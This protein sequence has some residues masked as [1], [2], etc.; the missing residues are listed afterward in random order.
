VTTI[1]RAGHD[2]FLARLW[3]ACP[4]TASCAGRSSGL[5]FQPLA[6]DDVG[7]IEAMDPPTGAPGE[8]TP[9]PPTD[10]TLLFDTNVLRDLQRGRID[11]RLARRAAERLAA[12]P[13]RGCFSPLTLLELGSHFTDD[14]RRHFPRYQ[15]ALRAALTL[16]LHALPEPATFLRATLTATEGSLAHAQLAGTAE[17]RETWRLTQLLARARSYEELVYGQRVGWDG[18]RRRVAFLPGSWRARRDEGERTFVKSL[19]EMRHLLAS[20]DRTSLAPEL[21]AEPSRTAFERVQRARLGLPA[22]APDAA[23]SPGFA[24]LFRGWVAIVERLLEGTYDPSSDRNDHHDLGLV[25]Y[26]A[27][28]S[29]TLVTN[30]RGFADKLGENARVVD[31]DTWSTNARA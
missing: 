25:T 30:D 14:E 10:E 31:F 5:R 27:D 23:T 3:A 2:A 17:R 13:V 26:L 16:G 21:R 6:A 29:L 18:V 1:D 15:G 20:R 28:P 8:D 24:P 9:R 22:P 7:E 19:D 12:G 11:A 4:P